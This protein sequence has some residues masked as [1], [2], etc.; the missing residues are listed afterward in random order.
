MAG[1]KRKDAPSGKSSGSKSNKKHKIEDSRSN[2]S[3]GLVKIQETET[4]SDPIVESDTTEHSGDDDG[5]SWPSD[6]GEDVPEFS[7]PEKK[8]Y[9]GKPAQTTESGDEKKPRPNNNGK[10]LDIEIVQENT[11]LSL[12]QQA[13]LK[14]PTRNKRS[15]PRNV[16]P[17]NQMP[18]PL[19]DLRRYGNVSVGN[20]MYHWRSEKS[21]LLN[22]SR[23][24]VAVSRNLCS[25]MILSELFRRH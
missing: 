7:P 17:P 6:N 25:S 21:W 2:V 13:H 22:C 23:L 20:L 16:K 19:L 11:T 4:D 5:I 15:P 1:I 8:S 3:E 9:S 18:I 10:S 12:P 14:N 24:S